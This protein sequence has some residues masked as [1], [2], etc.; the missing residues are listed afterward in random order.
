[1][2]TTKT[3]ATILRRKHWK[4]ELLK[5]K[6]KSGNEITLTP[7]HLLID[8]ETL[9]WKE[10]QKFKAGDKIVAPLKLPSI[11]EKIYI[12]D[13]IPDNWKVMLTKE[14][15]EELKI[16]ILRKFKN[17]AEF[18]R[19][20]SI[21]KDVLSGKGQM[22]VKT[23]KQ[24]LKD[25]E[26]Y[27]KWKERPL[28][29]GRRFRGDKLKVATITPELAYFLGFVYGNGWI[30]ESKR[31]ATIFI[32]QS[33]AHKKQI[34]AIKSVFSTFYEGDLKEYKRRTKS[35]INGQNIES[36][37]IIFHIGSQLLV[38]LYKYLIQN[39]FE[40]L[41]KLDDEALKAFIAGALDSDGCISVKT[42]NK[43]KKEYQVVHVEFLLSNDEEKDK[44]FMLALRRF[45]I[46]SQLIRGKSVNKIRITGRE[47]IENLIKAVKRYSVKVKDLPIK[48]HKVSSSSDKVPSKIVAKIARRIIRSVPSTILQKEGLWSTLYAYA[49]EKYSPSRIQ[50][51]KLLEKLSIHLDV[52][53]LNLLKALANRDYF[54]DEIIS[55]EEIPYDGYVYDLYVPEL[56]NFVAEGIIVHNCIDEFDKMS[57]KDR[58]AIHEALEQQS[59][60]I[61]KAGI[62]ATLNSR[63]TVIAA[64][65]PKYGRFNKLKPLP[66]QLDLPPTLLSRFD[67]IFV[68][69][70]EPNERLDSEIARHI[71]KVRRGE[72]EAVAPKIPYELLKKYIAYARKNIHP[73]L[74][75]EAMDEILHYYVKMRRKIRSGNEEGVKP[76][77][78]TPRQLEALIRLSEARARMRLSEVV[79]REDAQ[80]AIRLIEY[81]LKQ[82]AMDEEG[83][84][85]ISILEVG[86]SSRQINKIDRILEI[87]KEL[88]NFTENGAPIDEILKEAE[89]YNIHRSEARKIIERLMTDGMVYMPKDGFYRVA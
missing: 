54:L 47:D 63:T 52:H 62:T 82:V 53:T 25:L 65:N 19:K 4:G 41:F 26:I 33:T 72:A 74:S 71:L 76:I 21:S 8:G 39:N 1:M 64:A 55:I 57:D 79:T 61:S 80:D 75:R 67:L 24:V 78:I 68:L 45:D 32:V 49:N 30:R 42:S 23:F 44:A 70:D 51:K 73:V 3:K 35:K 81:T 58:S 27:E 6:F 2:R 83:F 31:R 43:G 12:L 28:A 66:E 84:L 7:D 15:K 60:S 40:N 50:I 85:D 86:K 20:Y 10:A 13:I 14:E 89:R 38:Y 36:E 88:E 46:Y 16:E 59:V 48:K 11:K 9:E 5:I 69:I 77:P 17:L 87:I 56:H 22:S 18:N 37:N 29:F 34:E